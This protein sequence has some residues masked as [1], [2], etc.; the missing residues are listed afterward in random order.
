MESGTLR[1][2]NVKDQYDLNYR[3][4]YTILSTDNNGRL[5]KKRYN[6]VMFITA[7]FEYYLSWRSIEPIKINAH[8]HFNVSA[9]D[10]THLMR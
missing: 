4:S 1:A 10:S 6:Y 9:K 2:Q 7:D 8:R 3:C 5:D